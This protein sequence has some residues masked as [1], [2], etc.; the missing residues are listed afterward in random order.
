MLPCVDAAWVV[1]KVRLSDGRL[2]QVEQARIGKLKAPARR[3]GNPMA[4][5]RTGKRQRSGARIFPSTFNVRRSRA[6]SYSTVCAGVT[7]P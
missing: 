1:R 3:S 7:A 6:A 2:T 4:A 5:R